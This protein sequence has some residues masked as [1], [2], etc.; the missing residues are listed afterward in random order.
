[1]D[2]PQVE[3]RK[4]VKKRTKTERVA[5]MNLPHVGKEDAAA[6]VENLLVRGHDFVHPEIVAVA[7]PSSRCID[8]EYFI[9]PETN[10]CVPPSCLKVVTTQRRAAKRAWG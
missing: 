1:M 2:G 8:W 10:T 6:F 4:T 3:V 9:T 7:D 5:N